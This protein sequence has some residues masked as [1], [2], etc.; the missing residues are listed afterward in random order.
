MSRFGE[1]GAAIVGTGFMAAVHADALRRLGVRVVGVVGSDL[2]RASVAVHDRALPPAAATLDDLIE[3]D[4]V[5]VVHVTSPNHVHAAH[6]TAAITA[7]KHVVCEKPL[8]AT[9]AE[10]DEL[11]A[12]AETSGRVCA[13]NFNNRYH[14]Q[15]RALR[16]LRAGGTLGAIH[17]VR[18]SYLQDWL[19]RESDWNWRIDA[20]QGGPMRAVG[21]IGV[22]W[23]DLAEHVSGLRVTEVCA[24][25]ARIHQTRGGRPVETEDAADVLLRFDSGACGVVS[26]SQVAAGRLNALTLGIDGADAAAVWHSERGEELWVGRRNHPAEIWPRRPGVPPSGVSPDLPSG[27]VEGFADAF[28]R[29]YSEVYAAV[30]GD[31]AD[32]PTFADGRRAVAFADAVGR[33]AAEGRW[34]PIAH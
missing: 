13:V 32:Y 25:T 6:V 28:V 7:G 23:F 18:G 30:E 24:Q 19:L 14:G 20:A 17:A 1:R 12:L 34:M 27:H 3:R 15:A 2:E 11:V 16:A 33:S 8:A 10:A 21:D 26:I 31:A 5:D 29:L 9:L 4:D 22:H